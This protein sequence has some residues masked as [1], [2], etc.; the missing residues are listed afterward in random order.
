MSG[1]CG[2]REL[3]FASLI[4]TCWCSVNKLVGRLGVA[5]GR[6]RVLPCEEEHHQGVGGA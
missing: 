6:L 3:T 4:V 5:G 2:G 1:H